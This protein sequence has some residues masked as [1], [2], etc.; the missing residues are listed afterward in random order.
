[1]NY[2]ELVFSHLSLGDY[3]SASVGIVAVIA[4]M[5]KRE[6]DKYE[7]EAEDF[8]PIR[9]LSKNIFDFILIIIGG[10]AVLIV[11]SEITTANPDIFATVGLNEGSNY[12]WVLSLGSG[13]FGGRL[14]EFV[15]KKIL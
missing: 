2:L 9:F 11:A 15:L 14:V 8:K 12:K 10:F 5:F 3:I 13:L 7:N 6:G 4:F 1:M